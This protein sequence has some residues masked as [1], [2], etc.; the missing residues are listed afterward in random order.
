MTESTNTTLSGVV[1]PVVNSEQSIADRMQTPLS[2]SAALDTDASVVEGDST[3][4]EGD[5]HAKKGKTV[6]V[7]AKRDSGLPS[8]PLTR[9][10]T[11]ESVT[12]VA[13][14]NTTADANG[15]ITLKD[16]GRQSADDA[17]V[18][19]DTFVGRGIGES[20]E[21]EEDKEPSIPFTSRFQ[22]IPQVDANLKPPSPQPWDLITPPANNN[23]H[24]PLARNASRTNNKG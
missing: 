7:D 9:P 12:R 20:G 22:G 5:S 2:L 6:T 18:Q 4:I 23:L 16:E 10:G 17:L 15:D 14:G 21:D 3:M 13:D 1:A 11:S 8:P 24:S 19:E